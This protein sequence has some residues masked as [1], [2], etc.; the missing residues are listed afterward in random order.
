[1]IWCTIKKMKAV[2]ALPI[3]GIS[4]AAGG[5]DAIGSLFDATSDRFFDKE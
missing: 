4:D 2:K 3:V 5:L 1:M